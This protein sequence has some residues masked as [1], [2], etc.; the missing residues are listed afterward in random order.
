[1]QEYSEKYRDSRIILR[2]SDGIWSCAGSVHLTH[3]DHVNGRPIIRGGFN[4]KEEALNYAKE[5]IDLGLAQL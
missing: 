5:Q 4:S 3:G 2:E 1:M